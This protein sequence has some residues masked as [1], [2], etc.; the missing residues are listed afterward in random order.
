MLL[1]KSGNVIESYL[2]QRADSVQ[3][4]EDIKG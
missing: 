3:S 4:F 2:W 1:K